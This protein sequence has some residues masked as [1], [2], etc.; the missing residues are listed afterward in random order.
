MSEVVSEVVSEMGLT[1]MVGSMYL[2]KAEGRGVYAQPQQ[3]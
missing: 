3:N 1:M 2:D